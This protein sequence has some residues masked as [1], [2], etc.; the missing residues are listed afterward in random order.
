M[1]APAPAFANVYVPS[2]VQFITAPLLWSLYVITL[3][4]TLPIIFAIGF[5]E[6][7]VVRRYAKGASLWKLTGKL[8]T[9]NALT[10]LVGAV[11]MPTGTELWPGLVMA[12]GITV[13]LEGLL[14]RTLSKDVPVLARL[15]QGMRISFWMN[16]VSYSIIAVVLAGFIYI[17][18]IGTEDHIINQH[19]HGRLIAEP[20]D[21]VL[22]LDLDTNPRRVRE[23]PALDFGDGWL[24]QS[25]GRETVACGAN[26]FHLT[27]SGS[28]WTKRD[29]AIEKPNGAQKIVGVSLDGRLLC[30]EIKDKWMVYDSTKRKQVIDIPT[31]DGFSRAVFSPDGRCVATGT[32]I[33]QVQT[34][35]V[36]ASRC[37][38]ATFS[39]DSRFAAW[40]D[41]SSLI[42]IDCSSG[43]SRRIGIPGSGLTPASTAW[44]PDS[45]FVAYF[46]HPNP[47]TAQYWSPDLRVVDVHTG[48]SATVYRRLF[49]CGRSGRMVWLR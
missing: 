48:R 27:R 43:K 33:I 30:C 16:A 29:I 25:D 41:E 49:T 45:R 21:T 46:G 19:I 44:S 7:L 1:M 3:V 32:S 5:I 47:F 10:S 31:S 8:A 36:I 6:A 17:P 9:I 13:V 22:E 4:V 2:L 35:K 12:F 23:Q 40:V 37:Y 11:T 38:L 39:P 20:F 15:R 14:L 28:S 26:L 24:C 34:G 18:V 42:V